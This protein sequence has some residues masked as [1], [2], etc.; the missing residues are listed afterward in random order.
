MAAI[1]NLYATLDQYLELLRWLSEH[2][3]HIAQ[4][5][6]PWGRAETETTRA[7]ALLTREQ[8]AWLLVNCPIK[9]VT[10]QIKEQYDW[11]HPQKRTATWNRCSVCGEWN[12]DRWHHCEHCRCDL[13]QDDEYDWDLDCR[14]AQTRRAGEGAE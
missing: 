5:L 11:H 4:C 3:D 8:D 7:I 6:R 2:N 13:C 12:A 10:D 14:L 1:D 9:W